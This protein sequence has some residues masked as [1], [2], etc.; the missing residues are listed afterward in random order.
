MGLNS[1]VNINYYQSKRSI[2]ERKK[3]SVLMDLEQKLVAQKMYNATKVK[4]L[5]IVF[6]LKLAEKT[7]FKD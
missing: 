6:H 1:V 2:K 7:L 4:K 5:S 3:R